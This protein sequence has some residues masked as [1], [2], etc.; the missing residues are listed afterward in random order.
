[1]SIHLFRVVLDGART[2]CLY[3]SIPRLSRSSILICLSLLVLSPCVYCMEINISPHSALSN[4]SY[5]KSN[6]LL[7]K[8]HEILSFS[9][10]LCVDLYNGSYPISNVA[11]AS[12]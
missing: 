8:L 4:E 5:L 1:M 9:L 10:E 3:T 12:R 7:A 11:L 6:L 2:D